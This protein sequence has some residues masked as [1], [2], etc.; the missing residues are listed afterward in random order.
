MCDINSTS[1]GNGVALNSRNFMHLSQLGLPDK[2]RA[3]KV[4][5]VCISL[6]LEPLA[7]RSSPGDN[8]P[9]RYES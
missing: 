5:V 1:R 2:G 4:L 8:R 9:L 3:I 6:D 7:K